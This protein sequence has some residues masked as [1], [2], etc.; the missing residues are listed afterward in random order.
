MH[1][2]ISAEQLRALLNDTRAVLA[3]QPRIDAVDENAQA[4][5]IPHGKLEAL[6][7]LET[8]EWIFV[9]VAR[10]QKK[11]GALVEHGFEVHRRENGWEVV[12]A[13]LETDGKTTAKIHAEAARNHAVQQELERLRVNAQLPKAS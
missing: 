2:I 13:A 9:P 11:G 6:H 10:T 1:K 8:N 12:T 3:D 5:V 7:R 4:V